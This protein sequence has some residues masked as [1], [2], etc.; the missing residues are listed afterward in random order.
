MSSFRKLNL[1][2]KLIAMIMLVTTMALSATYLAIIASELINIRDAV[3]KEHS[4]YATLIGFNTV[5]SLLF[6]DISTANENL[7]L[8]QKQEGISEAHIFDENGELFAHYS[9]DTTVEQEQAFLPIGHVNTLLSAEL[10]Q[11]HTLFTQNTFEVF[12]P[13]IYDDSVIGYTYLKADLS[14]WYGIALVHFIVVLLGFIL[15]IVLAFFV[16]R[17][18]QASITSPVLN[19]VSL[20][21]EVATK[22]DYQVRA[23]IIGD[24]ELARLG[25]GFN[26]M[27]SQIDKHDKELNEYKATLEQKV[28]TRTHQLQ[29]A[30]N[31]KSEF[32]ANMSHEIRTPINAIIG[33]S[34]LTLKTELSREQSSNLTKILDSSEILLGVINDILDFSKI[35]AGKLELEHATF[36]IESVLQK[37]FGVVSLS[38]HEKG[39]ELISHIARDVPDW[40][41]GDPLRLQQ[42]ITN[43]LSNAVKFTDTGYVSINVKKLKIPNLLKLEFVITDTGIGMSEAKTEKLF[44][45]FT[46]AD[47]STTRKYGGTGLGL[48]ICKQLCELM[49]GSISAASEEGIGSTFKF[50][51][52]LEQG[53]A[54]PEQDCPVLPDKSIKALVVDDMEPCRQS[55]MHIL[56]ELNIQAEQASNGAEAADMVA[57]A[58]LM[59][60]PF[61]F[62]F[63]DWKMPMMDG[64]EASKLIQSN[65]G[66]LPRVL[67]VS[68]YDKLDV[69]ALAEPLGI[70]HFIEKPVYKSTITNALLSIFREGENPAPDQKKPEV[71]IPDLSSKKLLLVEDNRLNVE[72]A[73]G[74]LAETK[75]E[76]DV[77]ENGKEAL[78]KLAGAHQYDLVLMDIQMPVM[79]GLKATQKIR[80]DLKQKLPIIAMSAH[81]MAGDK[82]KSIAAGMDDHI[83]KPI[84]PRELYQ[85]IAEYL[86]SAVSTTNTLVHT[87]APKTFIEEFRNISGLHHDSALARFNG[88]SNLLE[89]FV[90]DFIQDN[91]SSEMLDK[92]LREQDLQ[93]I[94]RSSHTLK[95]LLSYIGAYSLKELAAEIEIECMTSTNVTDSIISKALVLSSRLKTLLREFNAAITPITQISI[96]F[97]METVQKNLTHLMTALK[98]A[99]ASSEE[100]AI[101]LACMCRDTEW[102]SDMEE[103]RKL[104]CDYEFEEALSKAQQ[105]EKKLD[106]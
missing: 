36:S 58:N 20:M 71:T 15:S 83:T 28:E 85:T 9:R 54:L 92:A 84:E 11:K 38:A 6:S 91:D 80:N 61:D 52:C 102:E 77:A 35:E 62:V 87:D 30:N 27:L 8:L 10:L 44:E 90:R 49:G 94:L 73:K 47:T 105:L 13:I 104:A 74:Y 21:H 40:V 12:Q 89:N 31:A 72:I 18:L 103:V 93:A 55:L 96:P 42:I 37:A 23:E 99:D 68:A 59:Q 70:H 33:F 78:Q 101:T 29:E 3:K 56:K 43:I 69:K 48:A 34:R 100:L 76:I 66:E 51:I 75:A 19:V 39:L 16:A 97:N 67:M 22:E 86:G 14:N 2:H 26:D 17:R 53:Q 24:D 63:M 5:G 82:E 25:E 81:A 1:K 46:Q 98:R 65:S 41:V 45:S 57:R 64:I 50:S 106:S 32:L 4:N 7:K 88:M 79:D 95:T 60:T